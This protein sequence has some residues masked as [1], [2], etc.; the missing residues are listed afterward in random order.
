MYGSGPSD[1]S[2]SA[3][4]SAAPQTKSLAGSLKAK[5]TIIGAAVS[6]GSVSCAQVVARAGFDWVLIDMEHAPTS[7]REATHLAHSIVAASAGDCV[8]I[9]RTPSHGVEWIKWALDSGAAG[10]IIPM[11]QSREE[12]ADIIQRALYPPRGQRSFGPF[13]A[14]F[15]HTD[16]SFDVGKYI[17]A[18]TKELAI[19]PMIESVAGVEKAEEILSVDGVTGCFIGPFDLRQSMGLP[20]GDGEEPV[21]I[22][23]LEKILRIGKRY[24]L[25]IGTVAGTEEA[26]KRK[27]EMGFSFL[28]AGSDVSFLAAGCQ[29]AWQQCNKGVRAARVEKL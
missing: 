22:N 28:L 26:A 10:V 15:A 16:R 20:G 1:A 17:S 19:L 24:S 9:I 2:L 18:R 3:S 4:G 21:F 29:T 11:V 23:A 25:E 7:A 5:G 27:K 6:M 12:C 8:S 14:P 13:L